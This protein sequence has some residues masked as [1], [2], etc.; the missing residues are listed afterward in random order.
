MKSLFATAYSKNNLDSMG[1]HSIQ[2]CAIG[3][4]SIGDDSK[5]L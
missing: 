1:N 5:A 3:G 2:T 4:F